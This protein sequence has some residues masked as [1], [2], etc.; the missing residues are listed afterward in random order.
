MAHRPA[1]MKRTMPRSHLDIW[2]PFKA[3]S[4]ADSKLYEYTTVSGHS[5]AQIENFMFLPKTLGLNREYFQ[6]HILT[7][8]G[9]LI[10]MKKGTIFKMREVTTFDAKLGP[11]QSFCFREGCRKKT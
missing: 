1:D 11:F 3:T 10:N 9:F 7:F 8:P 4:I 6:E 5:F 2:Q